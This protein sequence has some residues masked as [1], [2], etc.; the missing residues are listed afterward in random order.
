VAWI[1]DHHSGVC[2]CVCVCARAQ[3]RRTHARTHARTH[4]YEIF[5]RS[6]WDNN[7]N[8]KEKQRDRAVGMANEQDVSIKS[9][10]ALGLENTEHKVRR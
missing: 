3:A 4:T 1:V 8:E 6:T 2:V 5:R 9:R 7:E 10:L